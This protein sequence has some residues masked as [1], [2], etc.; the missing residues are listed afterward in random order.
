MVL[1]PNVLSQSSYIL[2]L[3]TLPLGA[4]NTGSVAANGALTL[5]TALALTYPAIYLFF[6]AGAVYS[7]SLAGFYFCIMSSTTLGTIFNNTYTTG[8]PTIPPLPTPIVATGP[9]AYTGVTT[10]PLTG[11]SLTIPPNVLGQYGGLFLTVNWSM[12]NNGNNKNLNI[13]LGGVNLYNSNVTANSSVT[14]GQ[15]Y[16]ARGNTT[17][18]AGPAVGSTGFGAANSGPNT[19][20]M[21]STVSQTLTISA[22]APTA[23]DY[24]I[25]ESALVQLFTSTLVVNSQ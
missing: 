15:F 8:I 12:L 10:N 4:A 16:T 9:G 1:V 13:Q 14:S 11:L 7:G 25:L 23:T 6:P 5:G 2:A 17:L 22:S 21:N 19:A 20:A 3:S 24:C 18:L